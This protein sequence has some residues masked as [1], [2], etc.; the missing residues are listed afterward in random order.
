M[1]AYVV[2]KATIDAIVTAY[3]KWQSGNS[4]LTGAQKAAGTK[5]GAMLWRENYRSVNYRYGEKKHPP[6]Y[7]FR[8]LE[9][10]PAR[11]LG[12]INSYRYQ[13]NEHDGWERSKAQK[14]TAD[15]EAAIEA[16]AGESEGWDI[17][18]DE[19]G[20]TRKSPAQLDREIAEKTPL[21]SQKPRAE[22]TGESK[23]SST[24]TFL[25]G[26]AA[27]VAVG[28]GLWEHFGKRKR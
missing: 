25:L 9:V 10:S 23:K 26:S 14:V 27:A 8:P 17:H 4:K 22:G 1:S 6:A 21:P 15:L 16:D 18:D 12:A 7:V 28:Y 13:S 20:T 3:L 5:L 2:D 11:V 24:S 19:V